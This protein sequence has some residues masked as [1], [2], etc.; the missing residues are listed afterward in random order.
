M[1]IDSYSLNPLVDTQW[2]IIKLHATATNVGNVDEQ[3][4]RINYRDKGPPNTGIAGQRFAINAGDTFVGDVRQWDTTDVPV[5]TYV[6]KAHVRPTAGFVDNDP[7]NNDIF[8]T[9]TIN[10]PSPWIF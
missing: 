7:S 10:P 6:L 3:K 2:E 8:V 5:G 1:R 9:V 4:A